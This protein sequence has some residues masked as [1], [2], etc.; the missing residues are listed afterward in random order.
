MNG[1]QKGW[2]GQTGVKRAAKGVWKKGGWPTGDWSGAQGLAGSAWSGGNGGGVGFGGKG[3]YWFN[4]APQG[5]PMLAWS[6]SETTQTQATN[7][8]WSQVLGSWPLSAVYASAKTRA[9]EAQEVPLQN[10]FEHLADDGGELP[11]SMTSEESVPLTVEPMRSGQCQNKRSSR[12]VYVP[13]AKPRKSQKERKRALIHCDTPPGLLCH[14]WHA[15]AE[16]HRKPLCLVNDYRSENNGWTRIRAVPD[17][18]A[19]ESVAPYD[20]APGYQVV[21][22]PGSRRGQKYVSASGDETANEGEQRLPMVSNN[23]VVTEQ[24]WQLAAVTRPLQSVGE[25]CDAGNRVV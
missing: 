8:G 15:Q 3:T 7:E 20:M 5:P 10:R 1:Q 19:I 21:A 11:M 4:S 13:R 16:D 18:G 25:T 2:Q 6:G 17:S 9:S 14:L 24:K 12:S 23:G 22:G